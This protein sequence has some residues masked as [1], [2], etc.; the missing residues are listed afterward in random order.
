MV[1]PES[2]YRLIG[3]QLPIALPYH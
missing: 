3:D 2:Q 1:L